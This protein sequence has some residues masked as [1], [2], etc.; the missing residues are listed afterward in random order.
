MAGKT[1]II[2]QRLQKMKSIFLKLDGTIDSLPIPKEH[3]EKVK[4]TLLGD[5]D[6]KQLIEGIDKQRPPRLFIIGRTGV[7]KSSII[8]ALC[9]GYVAGVDDTRSCTDT[10]EL[11]EIK[12]GDRVLMEICDTRGIAESE[13][14]DPNK[15]AERQLIEQVNEFSPDVAI[16]VL[17]CTHRDDVNKDIRFLKNLSQSYQKRNAVRLP[18]VVVI[19]KCDEAFPQEIKDPSQYTLMKERKIRDARTHYEQI[20]RSEKLEIDGIVS[21]ASLIHWGKEDGTILDSEEI[22]NLPP[23]ERENLKIVSDYRYHIKELLDLLLRAIRDVDAQMGLRMAARLD[24]VVRR[25]ANHLVNIFS[26]LSG[27]IA[28]TPI[29]VSDIFPLFFFQVTLIVLIATLSGRDISFDTAKE[30]AVSLLGTGGVGLTLRTAA[31]WLAQQ[32]VKVIPGAGSYVSAGIA[33]LGTKAIGAGAIAYYIDEETMDVAK[34][35]FEQSMR[36]NAPRPSEE[37]TEPEQ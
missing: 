9:S 8:N 11:Y 13:R 29:P 28:L 18:M 36:K 5:N 3:K 25:M 17:G 4:D 24:E 1:A 15:S 34:E 33:T 32:I 31:R 12:D 16:L 10:A 27:G 6:L 35:R 7:G 23:H 2:E 37:P 14:L 20:I 30:F 19:N 21:V 22:N 26:A